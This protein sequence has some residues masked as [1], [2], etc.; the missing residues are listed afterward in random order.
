MES[1]QHKGIWWLPHDRSK[2][3][4]GTLSFDPVNGGVLNITE[5]IVD[6]G[7]PPAIPDFAEFDLMFGN[8]GF[9]VT[10]RECYV[11]SI[12]GFGFSGYHDVMLT[13]DSIHLNHDFSNVQEFVPEESSLSYARVL[14]SY[15]HLNEW[16]GEIGFVNENGT[17]RR[18]LFESVSATFT[19]RNDKI[20]FAYSGSQN[21][22]ATEVT[23]SNLA[24]IILERHDHSNFENYQWYTYF[25]LPNLLTVATGELNT[26]FKVQG[27]TSDGVFVT[28]IYFKTVG[29][30]EKSLAI[31]PRTMLFTLDDIRD[32]LTHSLANWFE[33]SSWLWPSTDLYIQTMEYKTLRPQ[34]KFLLLAQA[35]ES[36]H[37]NSPYVDSY[38]AC[39][40]YNPLAKSLKKIVRQE[41]TDQSLKMNLY[42]RIDHGNDY[43][44]TTR[45]SD[46]CDRI[47]TYSSYVVADLV[48]DITIFAE[49]VSKARNQ[50]THHPTRQTEAMAQVISNGLRHTKS[51]Q[52][53]FRLC[54]LLELELPSEKTTELVE[55]FRSNNGQFF[56]GGVW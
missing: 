12:G 19:E 29:F 46:I 41:V 2:T 7:T 34:T 45:L 17:I 43:M 5:K 25:H 52:I 51:M 35:L 8:V 11:K 33:K 36:Y 3:F 37:S 50:L 23:L 31:A 38:I 40:D 21:N 6:T 49:D 32:H 9:P 53:L 26:P 24:R 48:G 27:I 4:I 15:T 54:M 30:A 10:L 44:F 16:M 42:S 47:A 55:R 20:T 1:I 13:V 28:D 18:Q 14:L 39:S 22:S 56:K